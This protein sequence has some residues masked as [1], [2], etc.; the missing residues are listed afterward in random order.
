MSSAPGH[1]LPAF[2]CHLLGAEEH[3]AEYVC[4]RRF[5]VFGDRKIRIAPIPPEN[6]VLK[7][8]LPGLVLRIRRNDGDLPA[9]RTWSRTQTNNDFVDILS[10]GTN[11]R[12]PA[13]NLGRQQAHDSKNILIRIA[14][15][16]APAR[17]L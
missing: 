7:G 9:G 1:T 14:T 5:H 8:D 12:P 13:L 2:D 17:P 16:L 15:G 4:F 6:V 10:A 11:P 3:V